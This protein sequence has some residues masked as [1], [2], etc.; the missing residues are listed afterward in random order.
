ML[1]SWRSPA[2]T[3]GNIFDVSPETSKWLLI[4]PSKDIYLSALLNICFSAGGLAH[5]DAAMLNCCDSWQ[6]VSHL[7][8]CVKFHFLFDDGFFHCFFF[9]FFPPI[10]I[11]NICN[12]RYKAVSYLQ[13]QSYWSILHRTFRPACFLRCF[14]FLPVVHEGECTGVWGGEGNY[15]ICY[16]LIL[17]LYIAI[18]CWGIWEKVK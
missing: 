10:K 3:I 14:P 2:A 15:S 11:I 17:R 8:F 6:K 7:P 18:H 9:L 4:V 13:N 16:L 1:S 5:W 12:F